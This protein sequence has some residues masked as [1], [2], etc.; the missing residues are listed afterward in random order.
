M[1][2]ILFIIWFVGLIGSIILTM[3]ATMWS[4]EKWDD[5]HREVMNSHSLGE[6]LHYQNEWDKW[7]RITMRLLYSAMVLSI[8]SLIAIISAIFV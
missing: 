3:V 6:C 5:A 8:I 2:Q 7:V 1:E 4:A